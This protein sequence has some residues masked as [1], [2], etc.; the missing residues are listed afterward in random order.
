M[1]KYFGK[2]RPFRTNVWC[3]MYVVIKL[4]HSLLNCKEIYNMQYDYYSFYS[5]LP[6]TAV[7]Y[8]LLLS[9]GWT[10]NVFTRGTIS[11]PQ[12]SIICSTAPST[13]SELLCCSCMFRPHGGRESWWYWWTFLLLWSGCWRLETWRCPSQTQSSTAS[14]VSLSRFFYWRWAS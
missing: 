1:T 2:F 4:I 8:T 7:E 12:S 9:N 14:W 11:W 5:L 3:F 10:P 6:L 13:W